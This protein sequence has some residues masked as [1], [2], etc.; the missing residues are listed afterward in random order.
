M[1][2]CCHVSIIRLTK[3]NQES[4]F[5]HMDLSA[6]DKYKIILDKD[7]NFKFP[8]YHGSST[9]FLDSILKNGL[10]SSNPFEKLPI[11]ELMK[12]CYNKCDDL[13]DSND[14]DWMEKKFWFKQVVTQQINVSNMN[15]RHGKTYVSLS[16]MVASKYAWD[17][18]NCFPKNYGSEFLNF[19]MYMYNKIVSVDDSFY[20][21]ADV[22]SIFKRL[23]AEVY[24]ILI[25]INKVNINS[26]QS[27]TLKNVFDELDLFLIHYD[28]NPDSVQNMHFNSIFELLKPVQKE[29]FDVFKIKHFE[30]LHSIETEQINDRSK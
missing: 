10:G 27:E 17:N 15:W 28:I 9:L 22:K 26:L 12:E 3:I 20:P 14:Q 7:G 2:A 19:A 1:I 21:T 18:H 24:P 30:H 16:K 23:K 25:K 4:H 29:D 6:S 8:L 5:V 11:I 13:F